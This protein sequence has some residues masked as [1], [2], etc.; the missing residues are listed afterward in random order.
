MTFERDIAST[1]GPLGGTWMMHGETGAH[2]AG[3]GLDFFQ[4]YALGRGGVLGNVEPDVVVDAFFFFEPN[5]VANTWNAAREKM[6]PSEASQHYSDA[7]AEW[8]RK[9]LTEI[10]GL[11][12][13][14][15]L[16]ERVVQAAETRGALFEGWAK[17]P[18]PDDAPG[19]AMLLLNVLREMRGGAHVEA[20]KQLGVDRQVAL[21][22]NSP[23]MYQL[24]GWTDTPPEQDAEACER[25]EKLTDELV[26]PAYAVLGD[27]ERE[28]FARVVADVGAA[29]G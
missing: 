8:G 18:L 17:M 21:A 7:C 2:G 12:D 19:R 15:K 22:T 25:A 4:F 3:V 28:L 5:L 24:F 29:S 6:D 23:H 27:D 10:A 11:D 14:S 16:A 20:V 1:V 13:F 9:R 26:A